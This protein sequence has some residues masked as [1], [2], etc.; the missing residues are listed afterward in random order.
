MEGTPQVKRSKGVRRVVVSAD[1]HGV[2]PHAGVGLLRE[3]A[4]CTGLAE[5]LTDA[6]IGTC[7]G[8]P[9][10]APGRVFTDLA[11]AAA[12]GADAISGIGVLTDREELFGRWPR[13]SDK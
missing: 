5:G 10:H 8:V 13:S 3:M 7:N 2:V 6:L 12:D 4:E 9:A 1:G 11:V